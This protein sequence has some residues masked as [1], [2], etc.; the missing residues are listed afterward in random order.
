MKP[1]VQTCSLEPSV[2]ILPLPVR[3]QGTVA[4]RLYVSPGPGEGS[5]LK[6]PDLGSGS[7][8]YSA[9]EAL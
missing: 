4:S 9:P 5:A 6:G 1:D 7:N 8:T 3:A 2:P